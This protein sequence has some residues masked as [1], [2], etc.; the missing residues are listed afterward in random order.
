MQFI[1]PLGLA[2]Q[3]LQSGFNRLGYVLVCCTGGSERKRRRLD[4]IL[5]LTHDLTAANDISPINVQT[6]DDSKHRAGKLDDLLRLDN[7]MEFCWIRI[8]YH[9]GFRRH[10][11]GQRKSRAPSQTVRK[12]SH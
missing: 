8:G 1:Y 2:T 9:S 11:T 4:S 12:A 10:W 6:R 3:K 7:A 5:Q